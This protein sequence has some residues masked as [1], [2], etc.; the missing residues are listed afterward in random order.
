MQE[1]PGL[2]I[3]VAR[4]RI[5]QAVM[6]RM[7]RHRQ[8]LSVQQFWLLAALRERPGI[9]Q[10]QLAT[11]LLADA[12]TVSRMLAGLVERRLARAE[13]DPADRRRT[14]VWLTPQGERAAE[15]LAPVVDEIR[16]AVVAGMT[17]GEVDALRQG[18]R[19][20]IAS[21]ESLADQPPRPRARSGPRPSAI[22]T[23][24]ER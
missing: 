14:S 16:Q 24:G 22:P 1:Y 2:L 11:R 5:K 17:A 15:E 18:L 13:L 4:R 19:R 8:R 7:G 10:T 9:S 6:A 21:L 23:R 12:P 3:A 20:I